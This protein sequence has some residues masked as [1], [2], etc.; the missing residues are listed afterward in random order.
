MSLHPA[1]DV[2]DIEL[3]LCAR[4]Y[5]LVSKKGQGVTLEI[6]RGRIEHWPSVHSVN[7]VCS[8]L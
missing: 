4:A 3:L 1:T 7:T 6:K 5:T 2:A 8:A